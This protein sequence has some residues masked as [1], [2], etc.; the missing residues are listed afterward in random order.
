[1]VQ[2]PEGQQAHHTLAVFYRILAP[3]RRRPPAM[4]V[5][6]TYDVDIRHNNFG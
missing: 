4:L 2:K 6:V 3:A 1:L 5:P